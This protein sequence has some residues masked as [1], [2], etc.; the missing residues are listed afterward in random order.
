MRAS[1]E[2]PFRYG[3]TDL[4]RGYLPLPRPAAGRLSR[5]MCKT[6]N[7]RRGR[8]VDIPLSPLHP[9]L[10]PTPRRPPRTLVH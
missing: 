10:S 3:K 7:L 6:G 8:E 1:R 5:L 4:I 9:G 2:L